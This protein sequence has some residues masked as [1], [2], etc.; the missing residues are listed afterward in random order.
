MSIRWMLAAVAALGL[1]LLT[2]PG[3][4]SVTVESPAPGGG[5]EVAEAAETA[6]ACDDDAGPAPLDFTIADM[7]GNEVDLAELKGKV[8]LLNFWATWCGPCK[9]EIPGFIELQ[10][11]Y[12]DQGFQVLGLSV[13][14]TP[15]QI[16]PFAEEFDVNYPMLVGLGRDDF[17]DAYGPIWGL[18]VSYWIDREGTLCKTHMGIATKD[19]FE[20]DLKFLL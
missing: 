8:I 3:I 6:A 19:E 13:D 20:R 18:P 12:G 15:E 10:D 17:Q 9:V 16:R 7:N 2:L 14:D 1:G 11:E 4:R 5:G